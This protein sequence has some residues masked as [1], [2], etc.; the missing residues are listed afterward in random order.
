MKRAQR[1][2]SLLL[3]GVVLIIVVGA[4]LAFLA[5]FGTGHGAGS[6]ADT[7][8]RLQKAQA[9]LEQFASATGR[10][11]CPAN[12]ALDTGDED[13]AA[14]P[15]GTCNTV[16]GTIPWR[17]VGLRQDDGLDSWGFKLSYRVYTGAAGSLTQDN[18]ASMVLCTVAAPASPGL[19]A[20]GLCQVDGT[21]HRTDRNEFV[22]GK[23]LTVTDFGSVHPDAA[24][25]LISHG[26]S[27]RG[28]FT[29]VGVQSPMP[30][31]PDEIANTTATGPFVARAA[32]SAGTPPDDPGHFDDLLA[33]RS[34]LDLATNANI[35]ARDWND[36]TYASVTANLAA[37][38]ATLGAAPSSPDL[39]TQTLAFNNATLSVQAGGVAENLT[40]TNASNLDGVG[41]GGAM[42]TL[43]SDDSEVLHIVFANNA[44]QLAFTL[45]GFGC[46]QTSGACTDSDAA[47]ITFYQSGVVVGTPVT[48]LGCNTSNVA[49][50]TIDRGASPGGD[51]DGI[52]I[53][54]KPTVPA[55]GTTQLL[56]ASF[57]NCPEGSTCQTSQDT[58]AGPAGN[59]CP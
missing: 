54:P 3:V 2:V 30:S 36:P 19:A 21:G 4:I 11:P 25:V 23:G 27:G 20:G 53:A 44:Q 34:I 38:S 29:S 51:F 14:G 5:L 47:Q 33:Y 9:A 42:P 59:H 48:V 46:R 15:A 43:S 1:G 32:A 56:L 18:G 31:S 17:S 57:V 37:V 58:G 52:D 24:Y 28:A 16:P 45:T 22:A 55:A 40:L 35:A 7:R 39:G 50:F 41:G 13:R 8:A 10:L 49:S 6:I 26:P 12:P